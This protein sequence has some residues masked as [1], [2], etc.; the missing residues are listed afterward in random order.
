VC[1]EGVDVQ[2]RLEVQKMSLLRGIIMVH[3]SRVMLSGFFIP[4]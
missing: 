1:G 3:C 4:S 2:D